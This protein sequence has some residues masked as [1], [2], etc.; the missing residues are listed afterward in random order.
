MRVWKII[1]AACR[2]KTIILALQSVI[3]CCH[4]YLTL[5]LFRTILFEKKF[6]EIK[7]EHNNLKKIIAKKYILL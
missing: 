4:S 5:S 7:C 1:S 2:I 6:F 3:I